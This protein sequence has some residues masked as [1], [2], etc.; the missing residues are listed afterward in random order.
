MAEIKAWKCD[1]LGNVFTK[2]QN[3]LKHLQ[4][5][6]RSKLNQI[7]ASLFDRNVLPELMRAQSI[8]EVT[9]FIKNNIEM[10]GLRSHV[11]KAVGLPGIGADYKNGIKFDRYAQAGR[12]LETIKSIDVKNVTFQECDYFNSEFNLNRQRNGASAS[13]V[14]FSL[15][16]VV[17]DSDPKRENYGVFSEDDFS[18][19]FSG[20]YPEIHRSR[21][22]KKPFNETR[23]LNKITADFILLEDDWPQLVQGMREEY[24]QMHGDDAPG[25]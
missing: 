19:M 7:K 13:T 24:R 25:Y 15:E 8:D 18:A 14:R 21:V 11:I 5:H 3:Y 4:P 20:M 17:S 2:R 22:N 23:T 9:N 16:I 6:A 10:L 12:I 1:K